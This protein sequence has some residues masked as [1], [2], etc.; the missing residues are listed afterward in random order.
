MEFLEALRNDV[1]LVLNREQSCI[2]GDYLDTIDYEEII[3][4]HRISN[5]LVEVW[6]A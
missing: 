2:L 6:L 3:H 4:Q 5:K 1:C